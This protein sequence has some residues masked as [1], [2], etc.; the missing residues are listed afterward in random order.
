[1]AERWMR[2]AQSAAI[3]ILAFGL[4]QR[5]YC[6]FPGGLSHLRSLQHDRLLR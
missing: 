4:A 5:V 2:F 6:G 3:T 1:M